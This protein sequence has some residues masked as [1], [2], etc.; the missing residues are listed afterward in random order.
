MPRRVMRER[1]MKPV[2]LALKWAAAAGL[3]GGMF[4]AGV[5]ARPADQP[6]AFD[7]LKNLELREIGPAVMG[8]RID[9][10][11]VVESNPN[12]VFVGVAAG[13]VWK[14]TNNGTTWTPVFD[15]EA[16]STIGDIAIAP[17]DPSVVWVGTGE[18]NNRQSSSWGDGAYKSVD[19]GKT[20]PQVLKI[21][22]DTGVSDIVMDPQSPDI[23]YAAAYER[24]RTPYGF[25]GGGP[26]GGIYKTTDGGATWKKLT[27]GLPYENGAGDVGRIGLD[28]Y[29]KDPNIVYAIVQ[30]EK[31]GT[32][33]SDDKGETWKKMGDTNPRP[34]YY[35]QI[36]IDPNNDLRIWE[37][38]AQMFYSEDGGKKFATDRV[39]GI[40]GDFH[41][42]WI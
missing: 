2:S 25:N 33:R 38:G 1:F 20:W 41:A 7:R 11:A 35:S 22:N 28:I 26:D 12:I 17:S 8:G 31:G 21:N 3:F 13:G 6:N 40:H 18:P 29:R 19:G 9:D 27:K 23:L 16:V 14:T 34:S 24:R 4:F 30:H 15:K 42:M 37:L 32:Y 36:R 39:K 5:E 10:F